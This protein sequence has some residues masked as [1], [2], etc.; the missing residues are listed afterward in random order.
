MNPENEK[1]D[2]KAT[3]HWAKVA[4]ETSRRLGDA[5]RQLSLGGLGAVWVLKHDTGHGFVLEQPLKIA[6]GLLVLT[7]MIDLLHGSLFFG[8]AQNKAALSK[9]KSG[10]PFW[11]AVDKTWLTRGLLNFRVATLVVSFLMLLVYVI[12]AL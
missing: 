9:G 11:N 6:T 7:L 8:I 3:E 1:D 2:D 4:S 12:R 10:R 5:L